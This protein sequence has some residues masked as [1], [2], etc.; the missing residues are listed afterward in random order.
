MVTN[1]DD[2][3]LFLCFK[4]GTESMLSSCVPKNCLAAELAAGEVPLDW[5]FYSKQWCSLFL[6]KLNPGVHQVEINVLYLWQALRFT[7]CVSFFS[8][9][10][11][12]PKSIWRIYRQDPLELI[13]DKTL[14]SVKSCFR[15]LLSESWSW[16]GGLKREAGRN[17]IVA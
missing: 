15:Q 1:G 6:S 4:Y 5:L 8:L 14:K 10:V 13:K 17:D 3:S 16:E 12:M 7:N 9:S 2:R 11:L